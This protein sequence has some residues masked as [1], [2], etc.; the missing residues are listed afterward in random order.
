MKFETFRK[1][2]NDLRKSNKNNWYQWVGDVEGKKVELKGFN[3]WLQIFT[4]DGVDHTGG[5]DISVKEFNNLLASA[6]PNRSVDKKARG[7]ETTNLHKVS[8]E[9]IDSFAE[10]VLSFYGKDGIYAQD[11]NGGFSKKEVLKAIHKYLNDPDTNWGDGDSVDREL[12]RDRYLA[13]IGDYSYEKG[14]GV[15]DKDFIPSVGSIDDFML[16]K[17]LIKNPKLKEVL[18]AKEWS[19][20]NNEST[21][22]IVSSSKPFNIIVT[23]GDKE[24]EFDKKDV[25]LI[26]PL[27]KARKEIKSHYSENFSDGGGIHT[28]NMKYKI[29]EG[30][31]HNKDIPLYQV[32]GVDNEYV[33]EWHT[34]KQDAEKELSKLNG[35]DM[36]GNNW[37]VEIRRTENSPY[38]AYDTGLSKD[39]AKKLTKQLK[40]EGA[41]YSVE[42][43][44][45]LPFKE[46][47]EAGVKNLSINEGG[48]WI[49]VVGDEDRITLKLADDDAIEEINDQRSIGMSDDEIVAYL[50][51]DVAAN[52]DLYWHTDLGDSGLG[53][54]NASGVT[55]AYFLDDDGSFKEDYRNDS[56]VYYFN[57]YM[58]K[59]PVDE[60]LQG[61]LI[62]K[63]ADEYA[64]G[65]SADAENGNYTN[66]TDKAKK[67]IDL[68]LSKGYEIDSYSDKSS[69]TTYSTPEEDEVIFATQGSKNGEYAVSYLYTDEDSGEMSISRELIKS[70]GEQFDGD[71]VI[72]FT[73][74]GVDLHT[75]DNGK[76]KNVTVEK[77]PYGA[78]ENEGGVDTNSKRYIDP[79]TK[80][81]IDSLGKD[82]L[83][84]MRD[85]LKSEIDEGIL[86]DPKYDLELKYLNYRIGEGGSAY[87]EGGGE[88]KEL[89]KN[90]SLIFSKAKKE[91][92]D[93][94]GLDSDNP[95]FIQ[96]LCIDTKSREKGFGSEV[97]EHIEDYAINNN[98]DMIF[99]HISSKS[100]YGKEDVCDPEKVKGWMKKRGYKIAPNTNDFYKEISES[101]YAD[102]DYLL[103]WSDMRKDDM[104]NCFVALFNDLK[105][106]EFAIENFKIDT[107]KNVVIYSRD[108]EFSNVEKLKL[109]K[110]LDK[111]TNERVKPEFCQFITDTKVEEGDIFV[112]VKGQIYSEGGS[113]YE[114]GGDVE[115]WKDEA[116]NLL[117]ENEVDFTIEFERAEDNHIHV[118]ADDAE[119]VIFPSEE[120]ARSYAIQRVKEDLQESP[121]M[122]VQD[123]LLN[124][125]DEQGAKEHFESIFNEMNRGYVGDIATEGSD[126]YENRLIEE[127]VENELMSEEEAESDDAEVIAENKKEEMVDIL[128]S[129]NMEEDG[130]GY[131]YFK[132][133]FGEEQARMQIA[134]NNLID[135]DEAA[136][137]AV[138]TDGIAHFLAYYDH[139]EIDLGEF[140]AYRTN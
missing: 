25:K 19:F 21:D 22:V 111:Y 112:Y 46:G 116:I 18:S 113:T 5:M 48:N 117:R 110:F 97:L 43:I 138:D 79:I 99:G 10:Y 9:D 82:D 20:L 60:L 4:I 34:S 78:F 42:S 64:Q 135:I 3:T 92:S 107:S 27:S 6:F 30:R 67:E 14:G 15:K 109:N 26:K 93:I 36:Q 139:E 69:D 106:S 23:D 53:M 134:D 126:E 61:E 122:F 24:L 8:K 66:D 133:N 44:I 84:S 80:D 85:E 132:D 88:I 131:E 62:L 39:E 105:G 121:E 114:E 47:G 130:V 29:F 100:A 55:K 52:S 41:F 86:S 108:E 125:I 32:V 118:E 75:K 104:R 33:G 76:Y 11:Y 2:V 65:G 16:K 68:L 28:D 119:Y 128:T 49:S 56:Q 17:L 94:Y 77:V 71:P 120:A 74:A 38:E 101:V 140:R 51:E 58:I 12:M 137:D 73:N 7:G 40:E 13:P 103:N 57:D 1:E 136:E 98:H 63:G 123:W 31:D 127:M 59:S 81:H 96:H 87:A 83:I 50:F 102:G 37:S 91:H 35:K 124:H 115:E 72:L 45:P 89:I 129:Y 95:L 70:I 54:T 90:G